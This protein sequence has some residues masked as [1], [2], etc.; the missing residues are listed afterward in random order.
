VNLAFHP[1]HLNAG[2]VCRVTYSASGSLKNHRPDI[3]AGVEIAHEV[4]S[5][6]SWVDRVEVTPSNW[7]DL[8]TS[9]P[10]RFTVSVHTNE[11][12][13][14]AGKNAVIVVR[15]HA[16]G[17]AQADGAVQA[18]FTIRSQCKFEQHDKPDK[19]GEPVKPDKP[20]K[21][22]KSQKPKKR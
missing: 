15:L 11:K 4:V 2:G 16:T 14:A 10:A 22:D 13:P 20:D 7:E 1:E 18:T 19:P 17:G 12:W 9:K 6:A 3:V 5:G 21:P 8:G